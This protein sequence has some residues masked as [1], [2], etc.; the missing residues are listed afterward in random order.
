MIHRFHSLVGPNQ[1]RVVW[2]RRSPCDLSPF[3]RFVTALFFSAPPFLFRDPAACYV[4]RAPVL[5]S[6][7]V[8]R[9][10]TDN[11]LL[12]ADH[13]ML[14]L[15]DFGSCVD[16]T[17]PPT[18]PPLTPT[19]ASPSSY[20]LLPPR[21]TPPSFD[22]DSATE[23]P[24]SPSVPTSFLLPP[25]TTP[26]VWARSMAKPQIV[27]VSEEPNL[28]VAAA[29]AAAVTET[30]VEAETRAEARAEPKAA[31][32]VN[33]SDC[34]LPRPSCLCTSSRDEV[35]RDDGNVSSAAVSPC[36]EETC[37]REDRCSCRGDDCS[38]GSGFDRAG[39]DRHTSSPATR[40]KALEEGSRGVPTPTQL[41]DKLFPAAQVAAESPPPAD[42][43][44]SQ[45]PGEQ[46][47]VREREAYRRG[48]DGCGGDLDKEAAQGQDTNEQ[49]R[50][51]DGV[52]DDLSGDDEKRRDGTAWDVKRDGGGGGGGGT[53][54]GG[55]AV[56]AAHPAGDVDL[57]ASP[58]VHAATQE[59][60]V[61]QFNEYFA[62]GTPNSIAPELARSWQKKSVFDFRRSDV[63]SLSLLL[64]VL[65]DSKNGECWLLD[66]R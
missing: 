21:R 17:R 16:A 8:D 63:G 20:S 45:P 1:Y 31:I 37:A 30:Q 9:L 14:V 43:S 33:I 50:N 15:T 65:A 49:R 27:G 35:R 53:G 66:A 23:L 25:P 3:S 19:P 38:D 24:S 44:F 26:T 64:F 28:Q 61:F 48:S 47:V 51:C 6:V 46:K 2:S 36:K 59:Q 39:G 4:K 55:V 10:C 42:R 57:S 34:A 12:G 11:W 56:K 58:C 29:A 18:K 60:L 22:R 54:G 40:Y 13:R 32:E 41:A 7:C 62:A 5:L 52:D